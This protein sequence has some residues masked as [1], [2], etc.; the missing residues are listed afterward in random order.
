MK[1][2]KETINE[3]RASV[4][5]ITNIASPTFKFESNSLLPAEVKYCRVKSKTYPQFEAKLKKGTAYGI[6]DIFIEGK[7]YNGQDYYAVW[8]FDTLDF[9]YNEYLP[10][11]LSIY[12]VKNLDCLEELFNFAMRKES[13]SLKG[14]LGPDGEM[15]YFYVKGSKK[16]PKKLEDKLVTD[17]ELIKKLK[18]NKYFF[19]GNDM[20]WADVSRKAFTAMKQLYPADGSGDSPSSRYWNL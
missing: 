7:Q 16:M 12:Y 8:F 6:E 10:Y 2:L 20:G 15:H 11:K 13:Y 1:S 9:L 17:P 14:E 5:S 3:A 19:G 4:T 18:F